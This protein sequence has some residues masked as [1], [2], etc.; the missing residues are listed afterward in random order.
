MT[1][2]Y[3][4][5]ATPLL[6][7]NREPNTSVT[8]RHGDLLNL[9]CATELDPAVDIDVNVVGTLSGQGIEDPS[10]TFDY[11]P[12]RVYQINRTIASLKA[13]RSAVY[14]CNATVF[15]GPDVVNVIAS[16]KTSSMLSITIGKCR[17]FDFDKGLGV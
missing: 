16:E 17:D 14:T 3:V 13:A 4:T 11:I 6:T 1:D 12:S 9:T 2:L 15:P 10:G 8:L 7:V 5:V